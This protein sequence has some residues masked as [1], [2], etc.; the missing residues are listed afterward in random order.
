[1]EYQSENKTCQNCKQDFT[2]ESDD[3]AFYEKIKVPPP[4]FCPECRLQRRLAWR[5]E[6]S[7]YKRNCN[8]CKDSMF[9]IYPADTPFPVYCNRCWFSDDWDVIDYG[10]EY[11]GINFYFIFDS[12]IS[13][14]S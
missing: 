6:R 14:T 11:A 7:L 3:F 8:L 13:F 12:L 10:K 9:A 5:N 2:I 1:M 4:T